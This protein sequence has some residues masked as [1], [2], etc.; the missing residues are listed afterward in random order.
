MFSPIYFIGKNTTPASK[1]TSA[2]VSIIVLAIIYFQLIP[3]KYIFYAYLFLAFHIINHLY[4]GI[5]E[6]KVHVC[7][8]C[9]KKLEPIIKY[10][11]HI[12]KKKK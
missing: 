7:Y 9:G 3:S 12:C 8:K 6:L 2:I 1:I 11:K 5:L 10:E 4:A